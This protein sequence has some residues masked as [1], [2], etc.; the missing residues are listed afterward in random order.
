MVI[1]FDKDNIALHY[2]RLFGECIADNDYES[3]L[4]Y[5]LKYN[6]ATEFSDFHLACGMIY[7]QMTRDSD[8]AELVYLAY[9]EFM[10]HIIRHPDCERAYRNLVIT[11]YM[12]SSLTPDYGPWFNK[13]G[14]D[15]GN[16]LR[17][18][19]ETTIESEG[20]PFNFDVIFKKGE[21]G[22]IDPHYSALD[23]ATVRY[24][25]ANDNLGGS[26]KDETGS[27]LNDIE[28]PKL[29]SKIIKFNSEF[30]KSDDKPITHTSTVKFETPDSELTD[31]LKELVDEEFDSDL[32]FIGDDDFDVDTE[33]ETQDNLEGD[34]DGEADNELDGVLS[35]TKKLGA[36]ERLCTAGKYA[37]ALDTLADIPES[38]KNYY[39]V[40]TMRALIY[41]DSDDLEK[42]ETALAAAKAL[43]PDHSLVGTMLCRLYELQGKTELIPAVLDNIDITSYMS[44]DHVYKAFDYILKYYDEDK[45][46]DVMEDYIDEYNLMNMRLIY[47]QMLYNR[48]EKDYAIE[49][50]YTLSRI[51]YDDINV[52]FFYM[53]AKLGADTLP[54]GEE[55]PQG[56]LSYMVEEFMEIVDSGRLTE[57]DIDGDVISTLT[58]FFISLEFRNEKKMLVKMFDTIK[59]LAANPC[60]EQKARD[61]LVSPYVEPIVKSVILSELFKRD[62]GAEFLAE[63]MYR[64]IPSDCIKKLGSGYSTPY[65]VAYAFVAMMC[66]DAVEMFIDNAEECNVALGNRAPDDDAL[67]C[68][69]IKTT[70]G[71]CGVE[72]E[73]RYVFAL[74]YKSK[75]AAGRACAE[76][77]RIIKSGRK[78]GDKNE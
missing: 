35:A 30:L 25:H 46:L 16:I 24:E 60:F 7:L 5:L 29:E 39:Y 2:K 73:E 4:D 71:A 45:A 18:I 76:I 41:L 28:K 34:F 53:T 11:D 56:L 48:G 38:D 61:A 68:Y 52:T 77:S 15:L 40:L 8:D 55:A 42:A 9:R 23:G 14:I 54:V 3:A 64:P 44:G 21:Y 57:S 49:E 33:A 65:Y 31:I 66:T 17:E 74:G 36:A 72:P 6:E 69:L 70:L 47:A 59:R 20:D 63:V 62:N 75:A 19:I 22:E 27:T 58:E 37:A 51:F 43:R 26:A 32:P 1:N 78:K 50:L 13:R 12:R 10:L 67:A